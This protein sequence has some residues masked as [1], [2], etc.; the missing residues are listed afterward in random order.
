MNWLPPST[1][2]RTIAKI[3]AY[4]PSQR[5]GHHGQEDGAGIAQP[6]VGGAGCGERGFAVAAVGPSN[7]C[8]AMDDGAMQGHCHISSAR[9]M[10]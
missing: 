1:P 9:Q 4:Q 7:H 6:A 5:T 2:R 8:G 10:V 3:S